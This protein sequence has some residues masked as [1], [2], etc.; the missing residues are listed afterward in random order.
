L[1]LYLKIAKQTGLEKGDIL[2]EFNRKKI[3]SIENLQAVLRD[4]VAGRRY[5]LVYIR[6]KEKREI[7]IQIEP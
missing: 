3:L 5:P 4:T 1:I 7:N 2:V 6:D